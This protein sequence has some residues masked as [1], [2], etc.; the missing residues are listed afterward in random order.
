VENSGAADGKAENR[1]QCRDEHDIGAE[2]HDV[3]DDGS[4][5]EDETQHVEPEWGA[6]PGA[7]FFA[8][9]K[10]QE[11]RRKSDGR[12][13]NQGEWTREGR[14]AGIDHHE[15][16]SEQQESGGNDAPAPGLGRG[17]RVGSGVRQGVPSQVIQ[18]GVLVFK[19]SWAYIYRCR[20][21]KYRQFCKSWS[22]Q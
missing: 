21:V 8:K 16:E 11:K 20:V 15:S 6:N 5:G 10:L 4:E 3:G 9:A 12:D 2:V 13:H 17:N 7:A 19:Y 14:T 18:G 1:S 22:C